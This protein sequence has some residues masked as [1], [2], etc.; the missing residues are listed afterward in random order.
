MKKCPYCSEQ[1]QDEAIKCRYCGEFFEAQEIQRTSLHS[2]A[3]VPIH[4]KVGFWFCII[5]VLLGLYFIIVFDTSVPVPT[6]KLFGNTVGGGRV[7]N[8]GLMNTQ[9]NGIIISCV[10]LLIGVIIMMVG[11]AKRANRTNPR[12]EEEGEPHDRGI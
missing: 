9:Q 6:T 5:G 3:N 1:I 8:L 7:N 10:I 4:F 2:T 12:I 11:R